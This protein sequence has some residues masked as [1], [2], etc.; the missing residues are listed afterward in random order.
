MFCERLKDYRESIGFIKRELA[1]RL[2]VS[3]SYYN[4]V[5]N[6]KREPSK[7]FIEKLVVFSEKPEEYWL[8][9]ISEENY[10]KERD[11]FKSTKKAVKQLL[12]LNLINNVEDL[13]KG[14]YEPGTLEELL[15]TALKADISYLLNNEK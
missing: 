5:E 13:F 12:E 14:Q 10:A 15:I 11:S 7:N 4:M 6:G 8:Y 1:E 3:E 2:P 9:G